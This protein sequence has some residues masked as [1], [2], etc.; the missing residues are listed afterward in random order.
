MYTERVRLKEQLEKVD[1]ILEFIRTDEIPK[2]NNL[3][4][5]ADPVVTRKLGA[6]N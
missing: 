6:K 5:A 2:A 4:L 1:K 3:L